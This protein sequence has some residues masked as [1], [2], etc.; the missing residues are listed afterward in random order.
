MV[1]SNKPKIH[2]SRKH[3]TSNEKE[4]IACLDT[5]RL[6]TCKEASE[7]L[8]VKTSTLYSW[9]HWKKIPHRKYGRLLRFCKYELIEWS[10]SSCQ[11]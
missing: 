3:L 2:Y 8:Q 10:K 4:N 6:M 1:K 11:E 5:Y 7:F 9:V